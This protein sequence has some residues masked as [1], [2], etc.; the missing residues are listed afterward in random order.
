MP[1]N[2]HKWRNMGAHVQRGRIVFLSGLAA[3]RGRLKMQA[4]GRSRIP[5]EQSSRPDQD[6]TVCANMY[7]CVQVCVYV[8]VC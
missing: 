4:M 6:A 2:M 1:T 7:V 8:C 3:V 5:L